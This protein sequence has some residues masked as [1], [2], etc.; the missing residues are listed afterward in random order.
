MYIIAGRADFPR[1]GPDKRWSR[2]EVL[3][4]LAD[5]TVSADAV[6]VGGVLVVRA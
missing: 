1:R 3:E 6:R 2:H 5:N 4:W